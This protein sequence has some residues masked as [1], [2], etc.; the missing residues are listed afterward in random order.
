MIKI[1]VQPCHYRYQ[2]T[3][4]TAQN[5]SWPTVSEWSADHYLWARSLHSTTSTQPGLYL[6]H[7]S[8]LFST[9][10]PNPENIKWSTGLLLH[11][12][13]CPTYKDLCQRWDRKL[14]VMFN[15]INIIFNGNPTSTI[16]L[17]VVV[18]ICNESAALVAATHTLAW[19]VQNIEAY[20]ASPALIG[21]IWKHTVEKSQTNITS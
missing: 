10:P 11:W 6:C 12:I 18:D 20:L 8:K 1:Q 4:P 21:Y 7:N 19:K 9:K 16:K 5:Y 3:S 14:K 17:S 13:A 2:I 15:L